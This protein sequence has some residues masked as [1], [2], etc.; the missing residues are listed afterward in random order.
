MAKNISKTAHWPVIHGFD[1]N[2]WVKLAQLLA[3]QDI[4]L[5][6]HSSEVG[7][8]KAMSEATD[9]TAS[10]A[11]A[12]ALVQNWEGLG[13]VLSKVDVLHLCEMDPSVHAWMNTHITPALNKRLGGHV[14]MTPM[15]PNF[16]RQVMDMSDAELL[17]NAMAHYR[18]DWYGV[19]VIPYTEEK[20]RSKLPKKDIRARAVRLADLDSLRG[21]LLRF[22]SMNTVWT[23]AQAE[24]AE[25]A[26]PLSQ[27]FEIFG[28]STA[29]PQRE[30]QARLTGIWL[31][32]VASGQIVSPLEWPSNRVSATDILRAVVAYSGGDPSLASTS[33]KV[34]IARMPRP[35]RR[36]IMAALEKA[37]ETTRNPL[38]E[39]HP[40]RQ[41]WLRVAEQI[42]TGEWGKKFP[43][44][45]KLLASLRNEPAP[46]SWA[47]KLDALLSGV[48]D[49]KAVKT[50]LALVEESP[51]QAAR[52]MSRILSW[53]VQYNDEA[54]H[55]K[56]A[57]KILDAFASVAVK[58]DT[59]VLLSLEAALEADRTTDGTRARV[60][61]PKGQ[62]AYRYRVD[63]STSGKGVIA[64]VYERAIAVCEATL[65]ERFSHL[66]EL[67]KVYVESGM[68]GIIVPKGM[69]NASSSVCTATRGS[70]VPMA[71]DAKIVR[72]FLWWQDTARGRVDVDLSAVGLDGK[73]KNTETCN[74]HGL[75]KGGLVHS[76]DITSAPSGAAEFI[77]VYLDQIDPRTRYVVLAA[78]VYTGPAFNQIPD[79][80]VGWQERTSSSG[81]R[82]E[83]QELRA[84]V[85]KFPVTTSRK[86]FLG[87]AFDVKE[88]RLIW[89]D[90][91]LDTSLRASIHSSHKEI[92]NVLQDMGLY[93]FGQPTMARLIELHV[94]ARNGEYVDAPHKANTVFSVAPRRA[95]KNQ[96]VIC[97]LQPQSVASELLV[98]SSTNVLSVLPE[99][100]SKEVQVVEHQANPLNDLVRSNEE[101]AKVKR[102]RKP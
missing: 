54:T 28:P 22:Y 25:L 26:F 87:A 38:S 1:N 55:E 84:V 68:E 19:S 33:P 47:G 50:L 94:A 49:D 69:R 11:S 10:H 61:F 27:H 75:K 3:N 63:P 96:N 73:F 48:A 72:L 90:L 40:H 45:T 66:P 44:A 98:S 36:V 37:L 17:Y 43:S 21:E 100:L 8:S 60:M 97:A 42:H 4:F 58:V 20:E 41:A 15:Y 12:L 31:S 18:G 67:G 46:V 57:G 79:C 93:A 30:N 88:R 6:P 76:G 85:E 91:P 102:P 39:L 14:Q 53:T 51:G 86:G 9:L 83:I 2:G 35:L 24:L 23:P 80:F 78:N 7:P 99:K 95:G 65:L 71:Q 29:L 70:K 32:Q 82:G 64:S 77:D 56:L 16:P 5:A 13:F 92:S 62:A 101:K 81:Q 89:L 52:A 59:P 34:R 74:Y